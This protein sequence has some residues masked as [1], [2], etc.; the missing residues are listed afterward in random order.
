MK[1]IVLLLLCSLPLLAQDIAPLSDEF[2][3][4]DSLARWT[5]FDAAEGWPDMTKRVAVADGRLM[6]EPWTRCSRRRRP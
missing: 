6:V 3:S 5:R 4:A 2:A 1:R